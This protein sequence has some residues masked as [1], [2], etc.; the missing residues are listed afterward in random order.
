VQAR[1]LNT[2]LLCAT[3]ILGGL[4]FRND[5]PSGGYNRTAGSLDVTNVKKILRGPFH[6]KQLQAEQLPERCRLPTQK[7]RLQY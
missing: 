1:R 5:V 4:L 2:A 6:W 7:R 3:V